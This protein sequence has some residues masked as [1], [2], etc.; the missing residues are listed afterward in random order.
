MHLY[1]AGRARPLAGRLAEVLADPPADPMTPEWL[2]VPSDGMRRWLT[3]ELAGH[4]GIGG[5]GSTDGVAA[6]IIRAYPGTL[7]NCVLTAERD[8]PN[9]D[10]W[11]I[12]RLVWSVLGATGR[13]AGGPSLPELEPRSEGASRYGRARRV[14]DLFDRY[15][16]HR[17]AMIR[18]WVAGEDVDGT[19]RPIPE[20]AAWQP[21]LWRLVRDEAGEPSPPER[22]PGLLARLARGDLALDLPDRLVLFGFTLLPGGGFLDLARAAAE[23][24]DVHL[25]LLEPSHLDA[26]RLVGLSPRPTGG[27]PRLRSSD[28]T[29]TLI[30]QPLLRSWGRLHRETA[31]LL[32]DAQADGLAAPERV[33]E[34]TDDR[35]TTLLGCLQDS[36]RTNAGSTSRIVLDPA[37]RSVQFHACFGPTRQ[38]DAL[39]DA[40]L[41]LLNASGGDLSEDDIVVVCP[42]LERFAPLIQAAFGPTAALP[43]ARSTD[44]GASA[45]RAD[46]PTLR[47][48]IADQSITTT[49]PILGATTA[50]LDLVAG[51]FEVASVLDFLALGP[52]RERFRFDDE[53]LADI[54]QWVT[55]TNVRWGLD[56]VHRESFGLPE[57]ITANTWRA[58]LDRLLVGA[59][60]YDADL[61]LATGDVV[62]YGVEGSGTETA[63]RLAE[64]LWHLSELVGETRTARPIAEWVRALRRTCDA[65]FATDRDA[66]W[67]VESLHRILDDV[68]QSASAQG[69]V[70]AVPLEFVDI[71]RLFGERLDAIPGRPDY[72]RGGIT[73]SSMT[74]LRWVPFR[75]VCLLGMD[76]SAFGSVTAPGDDLA[77]AFPQVGD[78]DP[79]AEARQSLLEAVLAA[80]DHLMVVRDAH[81]VRTNQDVPRSVVVAELFDAVTALVEP[82]RRSE[83]AE[84]LEIDHPRQPFDERCFEPAL[85]IPEVP[86]SFDRSNLDGARARR[87]RATRAPQFLAAPLAPSEGTVIELDQLR[88][89]F[90][91]P[92]AYFLSQRL[93][94]H[95]PKS[96]DEPT[97]LLPVELG[98][99][100]RWQVAT[101]L[102]RSRL[103]GVDTDAWRAV[104]RERG[105]LPPGSLE[106]HAVEEVEAVVDVLVAAAHDLEV[107]NDPAEP[108]E[109]DV[110]LSGG[111]RIVG[112][113]PIRLQGPSPGPARVS[114]S[115]LKPEHRVS[116]WLDLMALVGTDPSRP[117]RSVAVGRPPRSGAPADV[118]DIAVSDGPGT[119]SETARR[120]LAVAVDCYRM[121]LRQPI[122]LFSTFSYEVYCRTAKPTSWSDPR[123]RPDGDHAAVVLAF[124]GIGFGEVTDLVAQPGDPGDSGDRLSRF[125]DYFYGA[126]HDSTQAWVPRSG[127]ESLIPHRE[128]P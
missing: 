41:H 71:Q 34:Q 53:S 120:A 126:M 51:R 114:Y 88:S 45:V 1:S 58:A 59:A 115:K 14:A 42:S 12:E 52:V 49:N 2:A 57:S 75:V 94:A 101:R 43:P 112:S 85:L 116:A 33:G 21:H 108:F 44:S 95:L 110:E 61:T 26:D 111:T 107:G 30:D 72:F 89:F 8:D 103:A 35:P 128:G 104:E 11:R 76:Q 18:S 99:L 119:R 122:P 23:R 27:G 90:R 39:R 56:P 87:N 60:V 24:R 70:S 9:A 100:Q 84:R 10:P 63:G 125:A 83:L 7:R 20:H 123:S 28:S 48:R 109:V 36:I 93:E 98:P 74:P 31:L 86:W 4:L 91:N 113:V 118:L 46:V 78:R 64:A 15:H 121:G 47:Y 5:P 32:A 68:I 50:L 13:R 106:T 65:L 67:Q 77:A 92:A 97:A 79:R 17:P 117:W 102:L 124:G 62:P 3:L 19:G 22:L 37:D 81:D 55:D 16:L 38:V 66:L 127:G 80:G 82:D 96:E 73:I 6:N 105:T 29:A 54:N 40:L 69:V 25:F